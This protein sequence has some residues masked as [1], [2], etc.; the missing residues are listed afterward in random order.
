MHNYN[1]GKDSALFCSLSY[2]KLLEHDLS[3]SRYAS[4]FLI[5]MKEYFY[6]N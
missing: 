4:L 5:R 6:V 2:A 3:H 1:K